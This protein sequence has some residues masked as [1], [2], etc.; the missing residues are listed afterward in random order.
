M[1]F[2]C[3]IVTVFGVGDSKVVVCAIAAEEM[4]SGSN[5]PVATIAEILCFCILASNARNGPA[6]SEP[7]FRNCS[8]DV[9]SKLRKMLRG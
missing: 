4:A 5:M 2:N 6:V 9:F 8:G 3:A 1:F 7:N